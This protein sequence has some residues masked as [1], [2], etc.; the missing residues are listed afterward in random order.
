[1]LSD[2]YQNLHCSGD[3]T[4]T[5]MDDTDPS[6]QYS[7]SPDD[8]R[9]ETSANKGYRNGTA[10]NSNQLGGG[11]SIPYVSP[12]SHPLQAYLPA[13]PPLSLTLAVLRAARSP[14]TARSTRSR[15][16]SRSAWM[17]RWLAAPAGMFT[18][19]TGP[20]TCRMSSVRP[21][22]SVLPPLNPRRLDSH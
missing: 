9:L 16:A 21:L 10:H 1:M 6:F 17:A 18:Y 4:T 15:E 7:G 8:W 12:L 2:L 22:S 11:V 13:D 19:R 20:I 3:I 14:S 5:I